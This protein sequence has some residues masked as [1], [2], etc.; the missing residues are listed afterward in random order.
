VV[1][2]KILKKPSLMGFVFQ[3]VLRDG[4]QEAG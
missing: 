2:D 1:L 3:H 4:D